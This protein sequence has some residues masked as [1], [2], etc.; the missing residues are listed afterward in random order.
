MEKTATF[1][2]IKAIFAGKYD[3]FFQTTA[4]SLANFRRQMVTITK[5]LP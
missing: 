4:T 3:F 5:I 1:N 2:Q